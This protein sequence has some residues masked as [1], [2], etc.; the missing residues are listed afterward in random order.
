VDCSLTLLRRRG[1]REAQVRDLEIDK[2]EEWSDGSRVEGKAAAATRTTAKYLGT[3][4]TIA[5]AEAMGVPLT[6]ETCDVVALDS[7]GVVE[8][9]LGLI[10]QQPR[11]WIEEQL[12]RQMIERPRTLMWVKGHDGVERNEQAD[13]R[14]KQ[15]VWI[16]E[17]M[18]WPDIVTPA[19]IRQSYPL[20]DNA[21]AHLSWP[22]Q[23]LRGLTYLSGDGKGPPTTMAERDRKGG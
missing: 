19:G 1:K 8:R 23:A 6:W 17:R 3:M 12:A 5:D 22:R 20:H 4:S 18:H 16:G 15:E 10:H 14:A 11:S 13:R 21:P 7:R 2:V 9:I